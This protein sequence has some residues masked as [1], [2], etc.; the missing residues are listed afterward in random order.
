MKIE[1]VGIK[2][3]K[4]WHDIT[5]FRLVNKFIYLCLWFSYIVHFALISNLNIHAHI[6]CIVHDL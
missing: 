6:T 1:I 2:S 3:Y 5:H 4:T